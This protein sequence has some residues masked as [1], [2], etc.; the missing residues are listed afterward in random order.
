MLYEKTN[1]NDLIENNSSFFY[2]IKSDNF[3]QKVTYEGYSLI[4]DTTCTP[5]KLYV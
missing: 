2:H 4:I 3:A 5:F 1:I